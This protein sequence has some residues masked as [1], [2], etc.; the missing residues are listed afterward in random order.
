[1]NIIIT[2]L[3]CFCFGIEQPQQNQAVVVNLS[4]YWLNYRH[5]NSG[6]L[7]YNTLKRLG[8][9]DDQLLFFNADD[10]ACHPRNVFP[11][12]M[13]LNTNMPNIYKDIIID[14]KGRDVSIEKYMRAML[15]RDVKGTPDSLRLVRGER[16]FIYLIGHGGEGFMKFQNRDEITSYDIEYMFK[17]MEIMK[18]YKEVMFVVDTC[19]ATSLSDRIK[20]K[21]I[22]TVGSSVTGQ[23]SYSGYISN[24]I[25]AITSDLWDQHQ[26]VLFQH[27]LNKESNM[28]V[29]DYLNYF[30]KNMLKSN[31]GW[32]SDLFNRPLSQVKM[33]DFLAYIPQSVEV[34]LNEIPWSDNIFN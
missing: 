24:E 34:D 28:T 4:R 29:Q 19:Q 27:S 6:V 11:G 17:E 3:L 13:R 31:H 9:L 7:I 21:N 14:Y 25:G 23:S 15:G 1:M 26:D 30:N 16:T 8:Y 18:R 20:A 32:R 33:T 5:T 10:H 12:E 22:I 2:L